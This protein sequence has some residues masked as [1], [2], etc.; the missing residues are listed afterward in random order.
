MVYWVRIDRSTR[1]A[2]MMSFSSSSTAKGDES[3]YSTKLSGRSIA[4]PF[5][6]AHDSSSEQR[7]AECCCMKRMRNCLGAIRKL[8]SH[9]NC[10]WGDP[11]LAVTKC[12]PENSMKL[13]LLNS[14]SR[15]GLGSWFGLELSMLLTYFP[16]LFSH[17]TFCSG[18][19]EWD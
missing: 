18:G 4:Q 6:I 9:W 10:G 15:W 11:R 5:I 17:D 14:D 8:T 16:H 19:I 1:A 7:N 12:A 2:A 3:S 13:Q